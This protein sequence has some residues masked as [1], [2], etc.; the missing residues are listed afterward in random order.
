MPHRLWVF[1][2]EY[3][4][5][6]IGGLGRVATDLTEALVRSGMSITVISRSKSSRIHITKKRGL[7]IIRLPLRKAFFSQKSGN[8]RPAVIERWLERRG[9]QKPQ[10]IL[11]HSLQF[12]DLALHYRKKHR[13]PLIYLSHSLVDSDSKRNRKRQKSQLQLLRGANKIVVPSASESAKLKK[14]YPFCEH[15]TVVIKH[16][17]RIRKPAT[18]GPRHRLLFVGRLVPLKGVEE[19]LKAVYRLKQTG[20]KVQLTVVGTGP[21]EHST[22]FKWVAKKLGISSQV[23]WL[24]YATQRKVQNMYATHH[25]V[26]MPSRQESF[27]LVALE[28]LARGI[29][30]VSTQSGGLSEFVNSQV[31]QI[32][33]KVNSRAIA[34]AVQNMWKHK[35]ATNRRVIAGRKLASKL[36]WPYAAS[37]YKK[38]FQS[39]PGIERELQPADP[40]LQKGDGTPGCGQTRS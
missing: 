4:P 32:I 16:G 17:I 34:D 10:A 29:P 31:A 39:I 12:S 20:E 40:P 5:Y 36:T 15:K 21:K 18:R 26:I 28:A 23:R 11:T 35:T 22:H 25:A 6:I 9:F 3:D 33:P 14:R 1:T 30:L 2:M 37:Q 27:G 24:G 19:L 38:L 7:H 8:Y 13:I